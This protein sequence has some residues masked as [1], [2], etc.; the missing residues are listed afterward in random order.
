MSY[1]KQGSHIKSETHNFM[2]SKSREIYDRQAIS[3]KRTIR[4]LYFGFQSTGAR[5]S[6]TRRQTFWML[7]HPEAPCPELKENQKMKRIY[8]GLL[9]LAAVAYG[10]ACETTQPNNNNSTPNAN[11]SPSPTLG[12]NT[13]ANRNGDL[14]A[15]GEILVTITI[16]DN[17]RGDPYIAKVSPDTADLSGGLKAYWLIENQSKN[18]KAQNATV[19]IGSFKLVGTPT[20]GTPFGPDACENKFILN[21]IKEGESSREISNPAKGAD[22]TYKYDVLLKQEDGTLLFKLDP[23]IIVGSRHGE[24]VTNKEAAKTASPSPSPSPSASPKASPRKP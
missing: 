21:F 9:L 19:E 6:T 3:L 5:L 2:C 18:P 20:P 17:D 24:T 16:A 12:Y 7:R 22:G 8:L 15:F 23:Q 1:I 10:L 11:T 13:N 14:L 4:K